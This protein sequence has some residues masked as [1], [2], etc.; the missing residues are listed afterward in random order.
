MSVMSVRGHERAQAVE[1]AMQK[2]GR[3]P[4]TSSTT[5]EALRERQAVI[6][7]LEN[8]AADL[9]SGRA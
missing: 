3:W 8:Y 7:F 9:R 5:W 2:I 1:S 6:R 4:I